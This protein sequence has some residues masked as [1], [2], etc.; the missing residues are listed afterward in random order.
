VTTE[1][2]RYRIPPERASAFEDAYRRAA[3]SLGRAPQ[4]V[5]YELTRCEEDAESY[6]LRIR[7]TSIREHVEG[8]RGGDLFG[9]FLAEIRDYIPDVE[10]MRHYRQTGVEGSGAAVPTLYEWAG[11]GE[12]LQRLFTAFYRRVPEDDV[13][14]PVFAK[15][16]P[17]HAKRVATWLGQV[18]GGPEE[19][20]GGHARMVGRHLGRALTEHQRRRWVTLLM[21]TADD[22]GLPSDPEFRSAFAAYLEWGSRMAVLLSQPGAEPDLDEPMPR[23]GWGAIRPWQPTKAP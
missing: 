14:A 18:F 9:E 5:D 21:D 15:M 19:Y 11:G 7:W 10:E 17:D 13:L 23:W 1:Y 22:A 20:D 12:A 8:F 2:I 6:I 3:R 4:C 16:H